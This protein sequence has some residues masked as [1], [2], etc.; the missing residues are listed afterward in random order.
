MFKIIALFSFM[1]LTGFC[2]A[3]TTK[4]SRTKPLPASE[5][6][7]YVCPNCSLVTTKPGA[8]TY[9]QMT[10]CK[11]GDFYCTHCGVVPA[12][13]G[14]CVYCTNILT[15]MRLPD[16]NKKIARNPVSPSK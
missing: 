11:V 16:P 6:V 8:C 7:K 1:A 3:Q 4:S 13:S 14:K 10:V 12:D 5:V 15:E 9:C 2:F